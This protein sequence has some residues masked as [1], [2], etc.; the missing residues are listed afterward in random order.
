MSDARWST[1]CRPPRD[2]V[3]PVRIDPSGRL[4]PTPGQA[5]GP[6]W[7]ACGHGLYVPATVRDDVPEQR[8]VE[9]AARLP[10]HGAVTGWAAARLRGAGYFDGVAPNGREH[11]PVPLAVGA[12]KIRGGSAVTISREPLSA[13]E[14]S[15]V[16]GIPCTVAVRALYDEMRRPLDWREAV[17]AMDM[18]AAAGLVS[19]SEMTS[20]LGEHRRWRR[21]RQVERALGH[22]SERSRS[23]NETRARLIWTID[24]G[25]PEPLVN[26]D[27]FDLAGHFVA[28]V[29]LLDPVAGMVGE[30][31]GALHR[32][33]G[34]HARDVAREHALRR[35][36]LEYVTIT[37]PDLPHRARVVDRLM[38]TRSRAGFLPESRR[39]WT[40]VPPPHWEVGLSIDEERELRVV[41][42]EMA[43]LPR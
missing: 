1:T 43:R 6:R 37:G 11:I 19:I 17:V 24:A 18:M 9:Q 2:L 14:V 27:V 23:P 40:V 26:V 35:L 25:L 28:T 21:S 4:G 30:F 16:T 22:A 38:S 8:I 3:R 42:A 7:R 34:R 10:S 39:L 29:D 13:T 20:Y 41:L 12:G 31:D 5:R 32:A 15:V 33:A 36:E